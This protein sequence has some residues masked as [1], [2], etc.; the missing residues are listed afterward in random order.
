MGCFSRNFPTARVFA[1]CR[2]IRRWSV[3]S[4]SRN[5]KALKG[6]SA[7]PDRAASWTLKLMMNATFPRPGKFPKTSQYFNPWYDGS[8]AVNSGKFPFPQ[9][10]FPESTTMPPIEVP[11]PPMNLVAEWTTM[12]APWS[13]GRSRKGGGH[14][15][16]DHERDPRVVRDLRDR[17]EVERVEAGVAHAFRVD[18][19]RLLR[20]RLPEVRGVF[21][22]DEFHL[23]PHL[24]EGVV[25]QVVRPP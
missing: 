5:W 6:D 21:R 17:G 18:R 23:D 9:S 10:N 1:L 12:S 4:P 25:E 20:E 13:K 3:S 2:S 22:V 24:R 7:G 15:V 14:R 11:W 19:L 16:V 8:G